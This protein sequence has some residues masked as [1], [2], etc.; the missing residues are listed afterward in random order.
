VIPQARLHWLP[1]RDHQLND[2]LSEVAETIRSDDHG[3]VTQP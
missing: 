1:G 3:L 2:D